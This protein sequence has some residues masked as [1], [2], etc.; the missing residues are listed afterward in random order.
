MGWQIA[1][2]VGP[3]RPSPNSEFEAVGFNRAVDN[4]CLFYGFA[5]LEALKRWFIVRERSK[6]KA[7]GFA[8]SVY[9]VPDSSVMVGLKQLAFDLN[10][11]SKLET[12]NLTKV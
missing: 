11:A 7:L 3:K 4:K 12:L 5:D 8:I 1:K 2:H 9:S 6:L 10:K